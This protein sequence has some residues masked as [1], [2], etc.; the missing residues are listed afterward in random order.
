MRQFLRLIFLS[1]ALLFSCFAV[2]Q[3]LDMPR[4]MILDLVYAD[5]VRVPTTGTLISE[6]EFDDGQVR[7]AGLFDEDKGEFL[8]QSYGLRS[9]QAI[10]YRSMSAVQAP[11]ENTWSLGLGYRL[12]KSPADGEPLA[13]QFNGGLRY[14]LPKASSREGY[15]SLVFQSEPGFS[16]AYWSRFDNKTPYA[17]ADSFKKFSELRAGQL[18]VQPQG[19]SARS[20]YGFQYSENTQPADNFLLFEGQLYEPSEVQVLI[21]D[22]IRYSSIGQPG[23]LSLYNVPL[24][25]GANQV[26]VLLRQ[27]DG[28]L[29]EFASQFFASPRLLPEHAHD[30]NVHGGVNAD[31]GR[32]EGFAAYGVAM[33]AGWT[34]RSALGVAEELTASH[35]QTYAFSKGLLSFDWQRKTDLRPART[36]VSWSNANGLLGLTSLGGNY[37]AVLTGRW[38]STSFSVR[39]GL[40]DNYMSTQLS[41][42]LPV[43]NNVFANFFC[44]VSRDVL[45]QDTR[46]CGLSAT[47][48]MN[49]NG[50]QV[51]YSKSAG[52]VNGDAVQ[53]SFQLKDSSAY[54]FIGSQQITAGRANW[55]VQGVDTLV[56]G[57]SLG[58]ATV[59]AEATWVGQGM[60]VLGRGRGYE[61]EKA[62][63]AVQSKGDPLPYLNSV[64]MSGRVATRVPLNVPHRV[65]LDPE[66]VPMDVDLETFTREVNFQLPGVYV[67]PFNESP[68]SMLLE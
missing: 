16:Q 51:T 41:Y 17:Q 27:R 44:S 2:A 43:A 33:N 49:R 19:L 35:T 64:E 20:V 15:E 46:F 40:N 61:P 3:Q 62:T 10:N 8:I 14:Q 30:W 37:T 5:G 54:S 32:A 58:G 39:K 25:N 53:G 26:R 57:D 34:M 7:H 56:A 36:D 52:D 13:H 29:R 31:S 6:T 50:G 60:N 42:S 59:G 4:Y 11:T 9:L 55:V 47:L 67:I 66:S 28:T 68:D 1:V 63:L 38:L 24:D 22:R 18:F 21:N 12:V 65:S 48:V 23:T 45:N